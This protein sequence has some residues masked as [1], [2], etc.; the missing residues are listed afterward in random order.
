MYMYKILPYTRRRARE[1][2]VAVEP[3]HNKFK[4]LKVT[5][6]SGVYHVGDTRYKDYPTFKTIDRRLAETR[7]RLYHF[8]HRKD[9]GKAGY[10]ARNLL[11]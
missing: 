11:W 2:G 1:L 10:Y 4:K 8:R 3:S 6:R 7:R 9:H 5:D